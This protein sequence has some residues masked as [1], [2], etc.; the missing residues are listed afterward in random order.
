MLPQRG[1]MSGAMSAPRIR[2]SGT[3]GHGSG[4]LELNHSAMGP[5]LI[6]LLNLLIYRFIIHL[7][8][9]LQI[10]CWRTWAVDLQNFSQS[11]FADYVLLA[12]FDLFF[13]PLYWLQFSSWIQRLEQTPTW[14]PSQDCRRH[15]MSGYL[16]FYGL[17]SL[18]CVTYHGGYKI[19]VV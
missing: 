2:T 8:C 14:A 19:V 6:C 16:S 15:V 7:F 4:A 11:G 3:P 18:W 5:T 1:L 13:S 10:I 9:F 17:D 12:Q